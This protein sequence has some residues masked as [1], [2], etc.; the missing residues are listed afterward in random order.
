MTESNN[1][2]MNET[3]R[4][5]SWFMKNPGI[6]TVFTYYTDELNANDFLEIMD[7]LIEGE[8]YG[9]LFLL[10]LMNHHDRKIGKAVDRFIA[11]K[12]IQ[13]WERIGTDQ[14]CADLRQSIEEEIQR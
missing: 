11:D 2:P 14:M 3:I 9:L 5:I 13:T 7:K 12:V 8:F 1:T 4:L 6:L 10:M